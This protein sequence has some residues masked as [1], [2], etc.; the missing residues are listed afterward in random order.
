MVKRAAVVGGESKKASVG[1][2]VCEEGRSPI[3]SE[4]MDA[5]Y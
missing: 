5:S 4:E 3:E 1:L 2:L